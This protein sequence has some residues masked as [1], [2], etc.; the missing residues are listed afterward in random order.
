MRWFVL[1]AL[2][3]C[4]GDSTNESGPK[5]DDSGGTT[6]PELGDYIDVDVPYI[7]SDETCFTEGTWLDAPTLI[8]GATVDVTLNGTV[9]DFESGD[10]VADASVELYF[11]DDINA[12]A[13]VTA[14][15][16]GNGGFSTTV[17]ACTPIG[18]KTYTPA[19]WEQTKD[20]YEV[21]QVWGLE[22]PL[23]ED[24][25]SVSV[26][27]SKI[28][29][30]ILGVEWTPGTGIIAGTAYDCTENK[31]EGAQVVVKDSSGNIADVDI[32][33]FI[34]D[35]PNADQPYTSP[36]GLW[37]AVNVP[38][39]TFNVEMYGFNGTDHTL[40]GITTLVIKADSVNISNIYMGRDDGIYYPDSC[41]A[42]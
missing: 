39:G 33:Y 14:T 41:I 3:A 35:F 32:F 18:Y 31:I 15:A 30:A 38:T 5:T 11:S 7:A 6:G 26:S 13:D 2:V 23:T 16:D 28:I 29:P 20:T 42:E 25:N 21:H 27:T 10:P 19:D 4:N 24:V 1:S 34:D 22:D 37:V 12:S 9:N 8:D 17:P 36:D 40:L